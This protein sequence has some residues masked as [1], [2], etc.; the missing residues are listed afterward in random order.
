ML[1]FQETIVQQVS[2]CIRTSQSYR[3]LPYDSKRISR[4][5]ARL[6]A[7]CPA[8][9]RVVTPGQRVPPQPAVDGIIRGL[10]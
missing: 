4:I 9:G 10:A 5:P 8:A 7:I 3:I 1:V 6:S 2:G